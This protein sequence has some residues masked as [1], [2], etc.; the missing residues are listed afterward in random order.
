MTPSAIVEFTAAGSA[1][2]LSRAI[3]EFVRG[4]GALQALVVPWESEPGC[5]RMAL[6]SV[7]SDG[8]AIEHTNLGTIVL[9]DLGKALTR[10]AVIAYEPGHPEREQLAD[11]LRTFAGQ[12]QDKFRASHTA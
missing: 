8:W 11:R 3:E 10:V 7:Q 1:G 6:T 4:A 12:I 9:S 5:V 2:P